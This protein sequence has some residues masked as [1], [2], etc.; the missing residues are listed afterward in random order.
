M[1]RSLANLLQ[2]PIKVGVAVTSDRTGG[3]RSGPRQCKAR[4]SFG[5]GMDNRWRVD[6]ACFTYILFGARPTVHAEGSG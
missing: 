4:L 6:L 5:S 1:R 2:L 3:R